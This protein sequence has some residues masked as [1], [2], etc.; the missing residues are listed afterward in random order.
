MTTQVREPAR[1][2]A[3]LSTEDFRLLQEA[4]LFYLR[5]HEDAPGTAKF[6]NLYHRLGSVTRR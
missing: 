4:V 3:V 5:A 6:S 2:R 1:A